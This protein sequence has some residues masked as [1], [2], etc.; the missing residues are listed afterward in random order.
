[1]KCSECKVFK[2]GCDYTDIERDYCVIERKFREAIEYRDAVNNSDRGDVEYL[3]YEMEDEI[4]PCLYGSKDKDQPE[5]DCRILERGGHPSE[6][7]HAK[8]IGKDKNIE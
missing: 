6:C 5:S 4:L 1:M 3:C 7:K 2:M 8:K